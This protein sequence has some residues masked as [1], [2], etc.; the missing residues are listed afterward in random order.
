[1]DNEV[2]TIKDV[3]KMLGVNE[4]TINRYA[5]EKKLPGFRVGNKWRFNKYEIEEWIVKNRNIPSDAHKTVFYSNSTISRTNTT[6]VLVP[7]YGS[8]K[9]G[10]PN[11][12]EQAIEDEIPVSS[13][14]IAPN[15]NYF[16]LKASGDSMNLCGINDGDYLL[17]RQQ[18]TARS[19]ENVLALIDSEATI[20]EFQRTDTAVILKPCSSNIEY[21]PIVVTRDFQIQGVVIAVLPKSAQGK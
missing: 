18:S 2:L 11:L 12:A 20:K 19:G 16:F 8:V 10:L 15:N 7:V 1:M 21:K 17:I 14:L 13:A 9:C 4:R 5:V 3:A 6:T